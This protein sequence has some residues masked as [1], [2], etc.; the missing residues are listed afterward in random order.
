MVGGGNFDFL[1][2]VVEGEISISV[3]PSEQVFRVV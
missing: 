3:F 2:I 1:F